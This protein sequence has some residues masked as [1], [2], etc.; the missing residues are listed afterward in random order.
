MW[1]TRHQ[2]RA[3][4]IS[5]GIVVI[6][7]ADIPDLPPMAQQGG[8]DEQ[9]GLD[10][11]RKNPARATKPRS[12]RDVRTAG[13]KLTERVTGACAPTTEVSSS[14]GGRKYICNSAAR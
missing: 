7:G 11:P 8:A 4:I 14:L 1:R 2:R 9:A 13:H 12:H 10:H 5:Q 6:I 3:P